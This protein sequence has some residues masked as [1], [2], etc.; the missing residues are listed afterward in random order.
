[1]KKLIIFFKSLFIFITVALSAALVYFVTILGGL[2]LLGALIFFLVTEYY[3]DE[4]KDG[5]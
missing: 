3:R 4:P 5:P 1:M 2:V